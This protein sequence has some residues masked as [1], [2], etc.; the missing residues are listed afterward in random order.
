MGSTLTK[1]DIVQAV[2]ECGGLSHRASE[3]I[4]VAVF[5]TIGT[6]LEQGVPVKL[7]G[8]GGFSVRH[9]SARPGRNPKTGVDSEVSAR[10]VVLFKPSGVLSARVNRVG[11]KV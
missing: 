4:V 11:K 3:G 10:T 5:E 1:S 2:Q 7:S 8:F 9:K 6:A